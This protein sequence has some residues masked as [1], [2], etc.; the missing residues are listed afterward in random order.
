MY[1]FG[2]QLQ[3]LG[4][5]PGQ[6]ILHHHG[7]I[8]RRYAI[9]CS[10][11]PMHYIISL[12]PE[13]VA[14]WTHTLKPSHSELNLTLHFHFP[15]L[16]MFTAKVI[17]WEPQTVWSFHDSVGLDVPGVPGVPWPSGLSWRIAHGAAAFQ[18]SKR[19][20]GWT[21]TEYTGSQPAIRMVSTKQS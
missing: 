18:R 9:A 15:Q 10:N 2:C 4:W 16:R 17:Q 21:S 11:L 7:D 5:D 8:I 20:T 13:T 3:M 12:R 1:S 19:S 6:M 14:A